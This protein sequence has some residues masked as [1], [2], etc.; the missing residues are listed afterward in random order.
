MTDKDQDGWMIETNQ[1]GG[2][3]RYR[4]N[5]AVKEYELEIGNIPQSVFLESNR[6][7][8]EE[9]ERQYAE[10][11]RKMAE[12]ATA[13]VRFCPVM[14]G[15]QND[16]TACLGSECALFVEDTCIFARRQ[17]TEV[18]ETTGL[19]C[20]FSQFAGRCTDKCVLNKN[21]GCTFLQN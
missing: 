21:G 10:D 17:V 14:M 19:R 3:R 13:P 16:E 20:P 6:R 9:R 5:G 2:T 15:A 4:M 12:R 8:R 1:W 11:R 7:A 18:K